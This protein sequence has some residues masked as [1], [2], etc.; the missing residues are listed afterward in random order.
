MPLP[1]PRKDGTL[2][3]LTGDAHLKQRVQHP[4]IHERKERGVPYW[5]FRYWHDELL[6]DG[7]IQTAGNA[8][9]AVQQGDGAL[10]KKRAE[11]IRDTFLAE[12]NAAATK[13]EAAVKA[14][15]RSMQTGSSSVGSR[16]CGSTTMSRK[17]WAASILRGTHA[18]KYKFNLEK[19]ILPRWKDTRLCE[20]RAKEV[21]DWLQNTC[22]SWHHMADLRGIMSGIITRRRT[23]SF[24]RRSTPTRF[25]A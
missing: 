25:T 11:S 6:P 19:Y 20:F 14:G 1:V 2:L 4:K 9:S 13:P 22:T 10:T 7:S 12:Q 17:R 23:G 16:N 15:S 18:G 21:L 8:T 5:Y 3:S 24:C